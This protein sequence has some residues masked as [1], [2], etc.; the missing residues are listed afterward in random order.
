MSND[1]D[2][3]K[4]LLRLSEVHDKRFGE[5]AE[6]LRDLSTSVKY[7]GNGDAA[8]SMGAIENLGLNLK[9]GLSTLAEGVA[10]IGRA[11][12]EKD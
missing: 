12:E 3:S 4:A 1:S 2:I 9:D 8:S 10:I 6:A 7:L 5:I 11:I